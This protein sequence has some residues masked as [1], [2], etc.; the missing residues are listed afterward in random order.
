MLVFDTKDFSDMVKIVQDHT[1][2]FYFVSKEYQ[3]EDYNRVFLTPQPYWS[4][5]HEVDAKNLNLHRI[6]TELKRM[7]LEYM[8]I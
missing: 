4:P 5:E 6:V 2:V 8:G 3:H 7:K 1:A